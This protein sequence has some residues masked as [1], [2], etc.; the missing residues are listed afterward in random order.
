MRSQTIERSL[1]S[2]VN[3]LQECSSRYHGGLK[4]DIKHI[5]NHMKSRHVTKFS[6]AGHHSSGGI[7]EF[8]IGACDLLLL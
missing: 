8:L 5:T 3:K 2:L 1:N 6:A 4:T 7:L